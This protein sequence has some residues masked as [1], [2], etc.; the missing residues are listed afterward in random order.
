MAGIDLH[1]N[2]PDVALSAGVAKT[3]VQVLAAA[4]HRVKVKGIDVSFKGVSSTDTPVLLEWVQ[5]STAG[6]MTSLTLDKHDEGYSETL[7]TT[8]QHTATVEP[9]STALKRWSWRIHPQSNRLALLP[10]GME[11]IIRGGERRGL[12]CTAVEAQ[13]ICVHLWLEE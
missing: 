2:T 7:Q 8:A 10:P 3:V 12:L 13:N 9:T 11:L 1:A 6:T 4:Q 5:Q